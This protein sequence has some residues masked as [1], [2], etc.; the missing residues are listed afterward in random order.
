M[1]VS[2]IPIA[3]DDGRI[4]QLD[5]DGDGDGGDSAGEP[6]ARRGQ[7]RAATVLGLHVP[8]DGVHGAGDDDGRSH[9]DDVQLL[10]AGLHANGSIGKTNIKLNF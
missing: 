10:H 3:D 8:A 4:V 5:Y 9:R 6:G 1:F 7:G 2:V